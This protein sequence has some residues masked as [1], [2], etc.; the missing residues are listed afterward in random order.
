VDHFIDLMD[1]VEGVYLR[2]LPPLTTLMVWTRNSL[3][4]MVVTEGSSVQ[5]QGG[6]FFPNFTPALVDGAS[7]GRGVLK[8]GWISVGLE[9]EIRARGRR[10][11][12]SPV[13]AITTE[14]RGHPV[15][16]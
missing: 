6:T 11:V 3:Y 13:Q 9:M 5:V 12:T 4:R 15:V 8:K 10:I 14:R 2:Q 16:H 7:M 1:P